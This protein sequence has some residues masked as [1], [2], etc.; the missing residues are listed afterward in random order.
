MDYA[1]NRED[2]T[3]H[4][5]KQVDRLLSNEGVEVADL[6]SLWALAQGRKQVEGQ[7]AGRRRARY[8]IFGA[9]LPPSEA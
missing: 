6:Q 4:T 5:T 7:L 3:K 1:A 9:L 2:R 8:S